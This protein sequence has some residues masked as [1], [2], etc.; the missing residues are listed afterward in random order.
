[1]EWVNKQGTLQE[2]PYPAGRRREG[3]GRIGRR[4]HAGEDRGVQFFFFFFFSTRSTRVLLRIEAHRNGDEAVS[5]AM[6]HKEY[7][8]QV[9]RVNFRKVHG[10]HTTL[11]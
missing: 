5:D 2:L 9:I 6:V 1:M 8:A 3:E 10:I 11:M 4:E 7:P